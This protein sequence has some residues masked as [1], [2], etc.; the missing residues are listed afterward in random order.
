MN[1]F[2]LSCWWTQMV[3]LN[4]QMCNRLLQW[5]SITPVIYHG[6]CERAER[7]ETSLLGQRQSCSGAKG[8]GRWRR[9]TPWCAC[10][11]TRWS[12]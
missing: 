8:C 9:R 12:P 7:M 3:L 1:P 6:L 11:W 2:N 10:C 4:K 5:R